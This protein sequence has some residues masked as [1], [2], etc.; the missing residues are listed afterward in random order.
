MNYLKV[1]EMLKKNETHPVYVLYGTE[2]FFIQSIIEKLERNVIQNEKEDL[3]LFDLDEIPLEEVIADAETYP[4]FGENKLI[5][6]ENTS[7]LKAQSNLLPFEHKVENLERYLDNPLEHTVLVFIAPY[8]KLDERKKIVKQLKK[9]AIVAECNPIR[10]QDISQWIT[11]LA[12]EMNIEIQK[13]AYEVFERELQ[14]NLYLIQNELQK[15]SLYVGPGGVVTKSIAEELIAKTTNSSA[16]RLVDAVIDKDLGKAIEIYQDLMKMKE[17]P[18]AIIGLLAYQFRMLL[19]V[20]LL[21]EK[22]YGQQQ[23]Q[24]NIGGHPYGIKMALTREKR[25]RLEKLEQIMIR[26]TETDAAMKQGT[27]DKNLSFEL[28]LYDLI[29]SK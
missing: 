14:T 21:R 26:L 10:E 3:S 12:K 7:F 9:K 6:A 20:K 27:M 17:E 2:P 25:F 1:L 8:Q 5:I 16:L 18:I 22:G 24:K 23:L 13:E 29:E 4:F 28:L 19:R 15:I 11:T